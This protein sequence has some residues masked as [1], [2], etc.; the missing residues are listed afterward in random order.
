MP[1]IIATTKIGKI[2]QQFCVLQGDLP[3]AGNKNGSTRSGAASMVK[4]LS[5]RKTEIAPK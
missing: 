3:N 4:I 5:A 2:G 1:I